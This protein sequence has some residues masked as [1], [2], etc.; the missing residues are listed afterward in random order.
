MRKGHYEAITDEW[1][2]NRTLIETVEP[3]PFLAQ[4]NAY[5]HSEAHSDAYFSAGR[6]RCAEQ[7]CV[8]HYTLRGQGAFYSKNGRVLTRA[9]QGV[10][11]MVND[12][13]GGYGYPADA[14][15][16]W[17]FICFIFNEGPS[18]ELTQHLLDNCG[19]LYTV[20]P[21][22]PT[23]RRLLDFEE[24][25]RTVLHA[26]DSAAFV[27]D[28]YSMLVQA[29]EQPTV[30]RIHPVVQQLREHLA[31]CIDDNPTVEYLSARL[32][33]SREY[34]CRLFHTH[35]GKTLKAYIARERT[36]RACRLLKNERCSIAAVSERMHYASPSHF[37]RS[38]KAIMGM[39]PAAFREKG[40]MPRF[41]LTR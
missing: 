5:V 35:T 7:E 19:R 9:G 2:F 31:V 34:L 41:D 29:A 21:E 30:P 6:Y 8:F 33:Y 4:F 32:G 39:T 38:F 25:P 20:P 22:H 12:P 13:D 37:S 26:H 17:E 23:I 15:E 16:P 10:L 1:I 28:V 24:S 40:V 3:A 11:A 14:T 27:F 36:G 18:R